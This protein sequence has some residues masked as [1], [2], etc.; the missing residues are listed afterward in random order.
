M[1]QAWGHRCWHE[2]QQHE[3][4]AFL[5]MTYRDDC[6]P[7]ELDGDHLRLF[8]MRL[9]K[10]MLGERLGRLRYFAVG[11]HGSISDHAHFHVQVFGEDFLR[12]ADRVGFSGPEDDKYLSP[13][14]EELWGFGNVDLRPLSV[15]RCKYAANHA[16][17]AWGVG[18][19]T[20]RRASKAPPLG[21]EWLRKYH[22][23]FVRNGFGTI[24]GVKY[25]IPLHYMAWAAYKE[26]FA[27]LKERRRQHAQAQGVVVES[28]LSKKSRETNL[29]A[30]LHINDRARYSV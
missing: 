12:F 3:R 19:P 28:D 22:D 11:E 10:W 18:R 4:N 7:G 30:R 5:T 21:S 14:L 13:K 16:V 2:A 6:R 17:K 24:D 8:F 23:D 25:A 29:K 20:F 27:P 15:G 1:G 26:A 9:R